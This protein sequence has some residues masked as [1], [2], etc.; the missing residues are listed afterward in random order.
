MRCYGESGVIVVI[1][2]KWPIIPDYGNL[3]NNGRESGALDLK[4]V[5]LPPSDP[6]TDVPPLVTPLSTVPPLVVPLVV[7]SLVV[8]RLAGGRRRVAGREQNNNCGD[9]AYVR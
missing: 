6:L 1:L 4:L 3:G 2:E 8:P 5:I 7:V 9:K